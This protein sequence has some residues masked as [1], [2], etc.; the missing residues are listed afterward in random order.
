MKHPP[1]ALRGGGPEVNAEVVRRLV[2]GD[3]GPVR[4]AVL[5]NAAGALAAFDERGGRLHDA[6]AAGLQ[7]AT[8]AVDDGR[9]AAK[10]DEW[11]RVSRQAR[12]RA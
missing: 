4:D 2:A 3:R 9:A 6:L 7:R 5:L 10:L 1:G 11:V 12:D 8:A